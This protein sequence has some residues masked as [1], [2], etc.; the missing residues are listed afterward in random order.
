MTKFK[1][2]LIAAA[3]TIAAGSAQA[4][5]SFT[6]SAGQNSINFLAYENHYRSTDTCK[7][8]GGCLAYDAD[9]DPTGWQRVDP[10]LT[11]AGSVLEGD[12]FA[13]V[14]RSTGILPA[15]WLPESSPS[16]NEFTGYFAHEVASINATDPTAAIISLKSPSDDPFDILSANELFRMYTDSSPDFTLFDTLANIIAKATDGTAGDAFWGSLGLAAGTTGYAYTRDNLLVSGSDDDFAAKSYLAMDL[17]LEGGAYNAGEL[18]LINDTSEGLVGGISTGV[19]KLCSAADISGGVISCTKF[20]GNADVKKLD[21]FAPDG[22]YTSTSPLYYEVND[23]LYIHRVPEPATVAL[24]G[25]GLL[26][27]AGMRRRRSA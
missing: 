12:V 4:A 23:P 21:Y 3:I 20:V 7:T 15:N 1:K 19:G 5:G 6:F 11:G 10:T 17:I 24:L 16:F 14:L 8:V 25:L 27:L 13:G 22:P 9:T 18:A 2:T 26:G